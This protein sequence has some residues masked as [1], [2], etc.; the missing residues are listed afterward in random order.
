MLHSTESNQSKR[1]EDSTKVDKDKDQDQESTAK[2]KGLNAQNGQC[3]T[4]DIAKR[5]VCLRVIPVK[6]SSGDNAREKI[7]YATRDEGSNTTLVKES[8]VNELGHDWK[9]DLLILN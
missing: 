8:L 9:V 7:T 1:E 4:A 5:Q 6:V 3:G 2:T